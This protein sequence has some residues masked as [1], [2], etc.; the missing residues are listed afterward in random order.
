MGVSFKT[1]LR[2]GNWY[3]QCHAWGKLTPHAVLVCVVLH[4]Q[5]AQG[6]AVAL[7]ANILGQDVLGKSSP[8][9]QRVMA[10]DKLDVFS[11]PYCCGNP[12]AHTFLC[13]SSGLA[14]YLT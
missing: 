8:W 5:M 4:M 9:H 10:R 3:S 12:T 13:S 11:W 6:A 14:F 7:L 1:G 2:Q